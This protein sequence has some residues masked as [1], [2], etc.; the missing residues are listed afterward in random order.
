MF[1][2]ANIMHDKIIN[3]D[4]IVTENNKEH[5]EK[6]SFIPD[7]PYKILIIGGSGSIKANVLLNLIKGTRWYWQNLFV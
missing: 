2:A 6:L 5:N 1:K 7:Y 4:R 3:L